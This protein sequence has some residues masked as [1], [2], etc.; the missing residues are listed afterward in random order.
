[1]V[2]ANLSQ[3]GT[4]PT[5]SFHKVHQYLRKYL[6]RTGFCEF[7]PSG[8]SCN[9]IPNTT[10][11]SSV[12]NGYGLCVSLNLDGKNCSTSSC[13]P[14]AQCMGGVCVTPYNCSCSKD[15]DC[16]DNNTCTNDTCVAGVCVYTNLT[17]ACDDGDW[18]NGND[19]CLNGLCQVRNEW[20]ERKRKLRG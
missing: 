14:D 3:T 12:C 6:C 13:T 2:L 19:T 8:S 15:A 16:F 1:M 18:C 11:T 17:I 5:H 9:G 20:R 4:N 7:S 10:C